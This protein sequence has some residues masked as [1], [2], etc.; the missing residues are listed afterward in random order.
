[1]S[2]AS[3]SAPAPRHALGLPAGSIRALLGLGILGLSWG[4]ALTYGKDEKLPLVFVYLQILMLLVLASFFAA[5]GKTIG[6]HVSRSSPLGLPRGVVRLLLLAGYAGLGAFLYYHGR[7]LEL[8]PHSRVWFALLLVTA[9]FF[10][11]HI[12]SR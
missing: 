6:A 4:I 11:G 10:L 3:P 8:E 7:E 12:V 5:H 2:I 9:G 1:M